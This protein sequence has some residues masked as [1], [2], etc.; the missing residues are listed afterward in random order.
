MQNERL[1]LVVEVKKLE[2]DLVEIYKNYR[3]ELDF[4]KMLL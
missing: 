1:D 4:K 2:D 3:D